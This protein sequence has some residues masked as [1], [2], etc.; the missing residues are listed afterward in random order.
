MTGQ[1]LCAQR[2]KND[3]IENH[4]SSMVMTTYDKI[5]IAPSSLSMT[6][7]PVLK[8]ASSKECVFSTLVSGGSFTQM[9]RFCANMGVE[10]ISK[11]AFYRAQHE[12]GKVIEEYAKESMAN[13]RAALLP[14][15]VVSADGRY[16]TRRN[17][18]HCSLDVIDNSS[19]RVLSLGIVD[20]RSKL[21]PSEEF[22]DTSNMMETEALKRALES[23]ESFEKLTS[24]VIDGN[25]K[26]Q[27]NS[28]K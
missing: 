18:S 20:K 9:N 15:S 4:L 17:S 1:K 7:S 14:D 19:G 26:E 11:T 28:L 10:Y 22:T 27:E 2:K 3:K 12:V 24:I 8:K 6:S 25:N 21:H 23:F 16:P 5:D 13:A